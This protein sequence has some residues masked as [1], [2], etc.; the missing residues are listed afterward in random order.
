MLQ[1]R[2]K[3]ALI[4]VEQMHSAKWG[5]G[6]VL[7]Q[8]ALTHK[9]KSHGEMNF[10]VPQGTD[11]WCLGLDEWGLPNDCLIMKYNLENT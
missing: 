9:E 1:F 11:L 8:I 5:T 10:P 3:T 6:S 4:C 7:R 2:G